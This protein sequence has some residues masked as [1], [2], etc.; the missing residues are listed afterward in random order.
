M[1]SSDS[2]RRSRGPLRS[3]GVSFMPSGIQRLVTQVL[4]RALPMAAPISR[5]RMPCSIQ[6]LRIALF[7]C[8]SVKPSAAL[9][10]AK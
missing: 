5:Q 2:A 3:A 1:A 6:N 7:G 10:W 4:P 8:E 9:G